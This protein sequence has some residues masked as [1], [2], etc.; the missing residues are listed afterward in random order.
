LAHPIEQGKLKD[1]VT[2]QNQD[3]TDWRREIPLYEQLGTSSCLVAAQ[4]AAAGF[5]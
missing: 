1:K 4:A 2:N 5:L 3:L